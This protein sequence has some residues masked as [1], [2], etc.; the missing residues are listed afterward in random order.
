MTGPLS[1]I[2]VVDLTSMISGP[3]ATMM[4]GD[5]GADVIK[6]EPLTG[7]LVRIMGP[8]RAGLTSGFISANRSKRS[9]A[10]DLKSEQGMAVVKKLVATADVFVQNFRPGAIVRMGLGEDVVRALKNDI[11]YVSISGFGE[12]GPY[13][14]K[15]VY[16]PVIQALCGLADIQK[17]GE[18]GRPKMI[19]TIIPDKTTS[20]T[21]AQAITAALFARERSGEGQHVKL[22]ML[23]TMVAYLW[24]EGMAGF[25]FIGKEVKAARAQFAQDLVF[26]TTD[27]YITA[28]AVSDAEWQGMCVALEHEE[29]LEDERF[30]TTN[31]RIINVK[32]RLAMTAEVLLSRSSA[33]WL[34]RLDREGVPCAPVLQRHEVFDHEQIRANEMVEE[35]DHPVA[36]RIRQPRPA[37]RFDKTP[38]AMQRH[39]PTLGQHTRELLEELGFDPAPLYDAGVIG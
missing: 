34:L 33:E 2:R 25:T 29:W 32:E 38:A 27:G 18:T 5:Q 9:L 13:A 28:G 6:V 14:H 24:P 31:G 22:A 11:V 12:T 21:A 19:R 16:D 36:G 1:G 15:R 7:D 10:V 39:A 8:N 35:F 3:V 30:K 26:E 20:V 37:A 17:D 4:L 23:D